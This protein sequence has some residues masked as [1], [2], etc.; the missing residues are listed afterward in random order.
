[1]VQ[2]PG[3][4]LPKPRRRQFQLRIDSYRAFCPHQSNLGLS[5]QDTLA[6]LT[7]EED[8]LRILGNAARTVLGSSMI[9]EYETFVFRKAGG[10]PVGQ[11]DFDV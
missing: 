11:L 5:D 1:M 6:H 10:V 3:P 8:T 9:P 4:G 7:G 2:Q